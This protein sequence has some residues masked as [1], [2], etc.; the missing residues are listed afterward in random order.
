[1]DIKGTERLRDEK[2]DAKKDSEPLLQA[3]DEVFQQLETAESWLD[4]SHAVASGVSKVSEAVVSSKYAASHEDWAGIVIAQRT[5]ELSE[6]VVE[7]LAKL[8]VVRQKLIDLR[9]TGK[10]VR[11]VVATVVALVADLDG[12]LANVSA[13]LEKFGNK[14]IE[15]KASVEALHHRLHWWLVFSV[16]ALT[17]L[18]AWF[19]ISQIGMMGH[20]WRFMRN[21]PPPVTAQ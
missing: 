9:D 18:M 17:L 14:V 1:M 15:T 2:A 7:I 5:Q 12:K 11:E 13:H 6:S 16:V 20:G 19:A 8:Q 3:L 21:D 4:S 10:L